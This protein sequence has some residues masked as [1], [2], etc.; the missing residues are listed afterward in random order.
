[1]AAVEY[2]PAFTA[3][4]ANI[5]DRNVIRPGQTV[6]EFHVRVR[7]SYEVAISWDDQELAGSS[8]KLNPG[9]HLLLPSLSL[10]RTNDI[11]QRVVV[12]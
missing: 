11:V 1:M 7:S 8:G 4:P 5:S 6:H 3:G 10:H 2:T 12:T 9:P